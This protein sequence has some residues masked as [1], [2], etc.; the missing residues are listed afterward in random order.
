QRVPLTERGQRQIA[1]AM[2]K[3]VFVIHADDTLDEALEQLTSH[4]VSW[5]PVVDL[6]AH[7]EGPHV[8]GILSASDI[9]RTYRETLAKSSRRMRGLVEGTVMIEIK[10]EA[11]MRLADRPLREAHLP[12]ESLIVSIRRQDELIFP[13]GGV[14]IKPGD[15]VTFL[16]SPTGEERLQQY[17]EARESKVESAPLQPTNI[18]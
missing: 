6:A 12:P 16:V 15:V 18:Q 17:L 11:G 7:P 13:R 1:S 5:A 14:I 8:I 2:N 9:T 10:I 4:R 3:D